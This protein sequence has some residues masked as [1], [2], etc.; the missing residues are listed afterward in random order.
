MKTPAELKFDRLIKEGFYEILKPFGFKKKKNNFYLKC[1]DLGQI[2][3]IQKSSWN[4][5]DHI[6]FTVNTGVFLPEHWLGQFYNKGK[7]LPVFPAESECII[8][9][10]IGELINR[11]DIWYEIGEKTDETKL[12]L[13]MQSHLEKFILPYLD[14]VKTKDALLEFLATSK[15]ILA[16]LDK[17]IVYGE[18]NQFDEA[19]AEYTTILKEITNPHFLETV[20]EY[21]RIYGFE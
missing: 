3:N 10:R 2:I 20:K 6:S 17:L 8:R 12:I 7:E 1:Q 4:S 11:Q 9:K 5:K 16:P 14:S 18:L 19:K 21:G 13:E 15:L